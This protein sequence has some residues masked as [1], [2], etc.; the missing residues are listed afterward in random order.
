MDNKP[1][2]SV[3]VPIYNVEK[4]LRKCVDSILN[5]TYENLEIILVDD[6]STDNCPKICD[7]Y[8][9]KDKRI[10]VIHKENG[11]LS[12]ARNCGLDIAKGEY[13][14]FVDSDDFIHHRMFELLL[15]YLLENNADISICNYTK[16]TEVDLK[17]DENIEL[18]EINCY[19]KKEFIK[20]L[21]QE[22]GG[23][24]I[25]AWNKLYKRK[26]FDQLR[27]PYG[28]QHEDEFIIHHVIDLSKKIVCI[29]EYLYYYLQRNNSIMSQK[30]NV[31][32][33]DYGY[34]LI[35]RYYLAKSKG[36]IPLKNQTVVILSYRLEAWRRHIGN[37]KYKDVY[38]DL[39][40]K[41][42]FLLL[43]RDAWCDYNFKGKLI[44]KLKLLIPYR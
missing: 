20:K 42:L 31:K 5:Q 36:Y 35:D 29:N 22:D 16:V 33:L 2:I 44:N 7:Y 37:K 14:G 21:V 8:Q 12:D 17:I 19:S 3:I 27:F 40:E 9:K 41:S 4:Y 18:K 6:G 30:F 34:A 11:G 24:Y 13:V 28:R 26:I 1:L 10:R 43:E 15:K 32:Y 23:K 39:R 38:N 25:V